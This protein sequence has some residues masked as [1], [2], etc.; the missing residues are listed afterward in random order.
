MSK[1][2]NAFIAQ[3][4]GPQH[5]LYAVCRMLG[6]PLSKEQKEFQNYLERKY[7]LREVV[8]DKNNKE[9]ELR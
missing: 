5:T 9:L 4:Q 2:G 1:N 6:I 3:T 7:G 8:P